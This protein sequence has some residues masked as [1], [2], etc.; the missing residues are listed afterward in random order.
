MNS[1]VSKKIYNKNFI[2]ILFILVAFFVNLKMD[3]YA[4][5]D[6]FDKKEVN[7]K[8]DKSKNDQT[9]EKRKEIISEAVSAIRETQNALNA[10]DNGKKDEA[11]NSLTIATGKLE[12]ILARDPKLALAPINVSLSNNDTLNTVEQI[13]EI[14]KESIKLL[15]DGHIQEVR[16]LLKG[17]ASETVISTT[18]LP[19]ATYPHAIKNAV[20]LLDKGKM[21]DAKL[22]LQE[23]LNTLVITQITIPLPVLRA[24]SSLDEAESLAEIKIRKDEESKRFYELLNSAEKE[25]EFAEALGYVSKEERKVFLNNVDDIR[26]KIT[27]EKGGKGFFDKIKINVENLIRNFQKSADKVINK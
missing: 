17:L 5:I 18:N 7:L 16:N 27:N 26:K 8:V 11:I 15:K 20:S 2:A 25:I 24:K 22:I 1:F 4:K 14:H 6:N 21:E 10:L 23:A 9:E 12:L 13:K 19:L 3:S